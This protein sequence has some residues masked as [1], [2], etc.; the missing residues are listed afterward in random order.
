MGYARGRCP[1]Y[2]ETEARDAVRFLI[3]RDQDELIRIDY[4]VEHDH[5]PYSHGT[6]EY[7]RVLGSFTDAIESPVLARQ[8]LAYVISYL[9]RR[10]LA[11]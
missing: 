2:P 4:V 9:R 3:G 7:G 8:A 6:L 10:P 5:H 11:A 1:R